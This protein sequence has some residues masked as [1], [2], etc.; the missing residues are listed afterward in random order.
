MRTNAPRAIRALRLR[1]GWRQADLAHLAGLSR[2][3]VHRI[4]ASQLAGVTIGSLDGV[5]SALQAEL[6][7]EVRWRG[8]Q[9]DSLIDRLHAALVTAVAERLQR[10]GWMTQVE[11]SFNHYGDR[12]RCD[13]VAWHPAERI[14]LIVEVK[15]RLGNLQETLGRQDVKVRLGAEIAAQLGFGAPRYVVPALVLV[16][17]G[18]NRRQICTYDALF[19][20]YTLRGKSALAWIRRPGSPVTGLLWFE[21]SPHSDQGGMKRPRGPS[22]RPPAR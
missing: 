3:V 20:R 15:T 13:L 18:A 21:S 14:L 9:L 2:D 5:I 11:V 10:S 8:A 12:G 17:H 1:R 4:E 7:V 16:E 22:H 6:V 19:R